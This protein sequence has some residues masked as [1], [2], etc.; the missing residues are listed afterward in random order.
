MGVAPFVDD[1]ADR[2]VG[3]CRPSRLATAAPLP[4]AINHANGAGT[5]VQCTN[6]NTGNATIGFEIY[7]NVGNYLGGNSILVAPASTVTFATKVFAGFTVDATVAVSSFSGHLCI[8]SD[9]A[10]KIVCAA[11]L[12]DASTNPAHPISSLPIVKKFIQK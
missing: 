4:G 7:G 1:V 10:S 6:G 9:T 11:W 12:A 3:G 2:D 5:V 8:V